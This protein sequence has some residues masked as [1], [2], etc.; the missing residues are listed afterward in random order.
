MLDLEVIAQAF[1]S[2]LH[3]L[4]KQNLGRTILRR[5]IKHIEVPIIGGLCSV[6]NL[7]E[8]KHALC[9]ALLC[10]AWWKGHHP[11][12]CPPVLPL[13]SDEI[14]D[15][16]Y[17]ADNGWDRLTA[18]YAAS[19]G[20]VGWNFQTHPG[21]DPFFKALLNSREC[22]ESLQTDADL[23]EYLGPGMRLVGFDD[24]TLRWHPPVPNNIDQRIAD[25]LM[26]PEILKV[27]RSQ[28]CTLS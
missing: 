25:I 17:Y 27:G 12:Q 20:G 4:V 2:H 8:A 11:T 16:Q 5:G 24:R 7:Q 1:D 22:P 21:F 14:A 6:N 28:G 13:S 3:H 15:L 23:V 9:A 18:Y 10:R 19:L 26:G